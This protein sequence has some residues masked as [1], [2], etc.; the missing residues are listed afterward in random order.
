M[1]TFSA[2]GMAVPGF[3]LGLTLIILLSVRWT[4][5]PPGGYVPFREDPGENLQR[6]IMPAF[7]LGVYL[8]ATLMRFLRAEMIEVM[9]ADYVRTARS[10]GLRERAIVYSHALRNALVPVITIIGIEL[11]H[12]VGGAVIIEQ[13]FGWSGMGWLTV[14]ALFDRDYPVVQASVLLIGA[15]LIVTSFLVDIAYAYLNPR[16]RADLGA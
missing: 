6:L 3:W 13:V 14:Q 10:K 7:T 11:G 8:S 1:M 12:L 16:L 2:A 15:S 9:A 5:L 4:L